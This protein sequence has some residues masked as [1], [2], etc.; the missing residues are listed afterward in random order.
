MHTIT[1]LAVDDAGTKLACYG[2]ESPLIDDASDT[3]FIFVLNPST[4]STASGLMKIT[5]T[6]EGEGYRVTSAGFLVDSDGG[7]FM[8]MNDLNPDPSQSRE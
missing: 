3:G 5:M 4:G 1:A 8:A 7:V 6:F 2:Y